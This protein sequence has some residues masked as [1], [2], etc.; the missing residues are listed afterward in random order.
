MEHK[1]INDFFESVKDKDSYSWIVYEL[2]ISKNISCADTDFETLNELKKLK[3]QASQ[4][5]DKSVLEEKCI[6]FENF[7]GYSIVRVFD[8]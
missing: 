3:S 6:E 4:S 8:D 1:S 7:D 2:K 5:N